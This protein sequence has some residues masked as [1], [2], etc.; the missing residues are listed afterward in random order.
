MPAQPKNGVCVSFRQV[1]KTFKMPF[2]SIENA[3]VTR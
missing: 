2:F 1:S 3:V